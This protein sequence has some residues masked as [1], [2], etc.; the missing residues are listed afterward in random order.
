[1][2]K[3]SILL[4]DAILKF[5]EHKESIKKCSRQTENS[6]FEYLF[7]LCT[8]RRVATKPLECTIQL[9]LECNNYFNFEYNIQ[10]ASVS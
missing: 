8:Q 5:I 10:S 6:F 3:A 2:E 7:E 9:N 1:M 4:E